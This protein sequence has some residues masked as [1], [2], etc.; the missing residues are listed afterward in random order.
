MINLDMVGR[1]REGRITS[2][3][4][5]SAPEW[6][7][8]LEEI[9]GRFDLK[10]AGGGDGYGPSDQMAF[11]QEDIPVVH[12][13]TGAHT[14]YHTPEDD[15]VTL[16]VDGG[17]WVARFVEDLLAELVTRRRHLTFT[18]SSGTPVTGGDSRDFGAYLGSIPDY[19]TMG[20][21]EGG[22]LLSAVRVDGPADRAGL[23]GGDT[24]VAMA[25]IEIHNLYD[26]TFVLR[27]HRPGETIAV[28]VLRDG[29]RVS[30][31][32]TL[33]R[34]GA[35]PSGESHTDDSSDEWAPRAGVD[36][37][38][39]RD[40]R[41]VH[42]ADLRQLTFDGENAEAYFSPDGRSLVFQRT[43]PDG[44]CDQ[45]Y[46]L[47]LTTSETVM[48]SSGKGRTTCGY[49][50]FPGGKRLIYATTEHVDDACPTKPD[51]SQG[52]VWGLYDF[53]LVWQEGPGATPETFASVPGAYDAEATV[54]MKDGRVVF[55]STRDGDLDIYVVDPDGTG[56]R[57][58]TNTVGYDGG[59][60][61]TPD[62]SGIVFRASRPTGT[63]LDDYRALLADGLVRPSA[64]EIFWMDS[65]G[66]KV[67]QLTDNRRAN[68]APYPTPDGRAVLFSSNLGG[69]E[70]EFDLRLVSLDGG[71]TEQITY[72][73]GFDGFPMFSPDGRWLVFASNRAG[74]RQTNIYIARWIP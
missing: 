11:Y 66:E 2:L 70:R 40:E 59:A 46:L 41:E 18:A 22:V 13:F 39:L 51:R 43:P 63:A 35:A 5:D 74:G 49:Y 27:E 16:N 12:L 24:I 50:S 30:V 44:E 60:F 69:S 31:R 23:R 37:S 10:L 64:L 32:A 7:P 48:L 62:C 45:Q 28:T 52:Y 14:E 57:R 71:E 38:H 42:L 53:D 3:G 21:R 55:T 17:K 26:M 15:V 25:G 9:A 47:D 68:F 20:A 58:L 73:A 29:E 34:R 54:C 36:A 65:D 67:R 8:L 61:F 33:D 4:S 72:T 6:L 1:L 56:L 19:S